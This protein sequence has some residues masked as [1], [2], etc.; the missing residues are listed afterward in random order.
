MKILPVRG[1]EVS[2]SGVSE[3]P[4]RVLS[5]VFGIRERQWIF[6]VALADPL[7]DRLEV[8]WTFS[9]P[10]IPETAPLLVAYNSKVPIV[11]PY[12]EDEQ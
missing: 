8:T 4:F 9:L 3:A 11:L 6:T 10:D 2:P 12:T 5:A 1:A 7:L